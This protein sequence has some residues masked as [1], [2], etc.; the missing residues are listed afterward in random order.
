LRHDF[1]AILVA[2]GLRDY[3]TGTWEGGDPGCD[4]V[5]RTMKPS[6]A[7]TLADHGEDGRSPYLDG[8]RGIPYRDLCGKCG[9]R[10]VDRQLGLEPTPDAYIANMV[11]VFREVRRVLRPDG[12]C[13][14]NLGDSYANDGKWGGSTGGKHVGGRDGTEG[15]RLKRETGLK[16]KDLV[17]IPWRV[18]F[19][20]QADGWWLRADVIWAKPNP[21]PESVTDRPTKAHEYVFLLTKS[22]RY[23]WDAEAVKEQSA[24]PE[25]S[26]ARYEKPFFVGPKHEAGGYSASGAKHTAGMKTFS[27]TRNLRSVWTIATQSF[28][29]AHFAT[30]PPALA[31][32]CIKA[33]TSAKGCCPACGAPWVRVVERTVTGTRKVCPKDS[34]PDRQ[35]GPEV[36]TS[37]LHSQ[38][39]HYSAATTGFRPSCAC[40]PAAPV[41]CTVLDPFAGAGTGLLVADRL[42]RHAIGIDLNTAY[43]EMAVRRIRSDAPLLAEVTV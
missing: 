40:P 11:A 18:A 9:A 29:E 35:D 43:A 39:F 34:N 23:F 26:A 25:G 42:Q 7:S 21:M 6:A 37:R 4:H 33:G 36:G 31:E 32:T 14:L 22:A 41:P 19:A 27:G 2:W 12:V 28:S 38:Y 8:L 10:R 1:A 20:L 30:F 3:G 16:P 24:D 5:E 13:W 15:Y 17:G